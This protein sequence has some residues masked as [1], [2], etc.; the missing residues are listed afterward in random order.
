[1]T[2]NELRQLALYMAN[3]NVE[4]F[5]KEVYG[6]AFEVDSYTIE[7]CNKMRSNTIAWLC[8]LD[9]VRLDQLATAALNR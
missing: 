5:T 8:E 1:M 7:K 2:G 3:T 4:D 9:E 6:Q